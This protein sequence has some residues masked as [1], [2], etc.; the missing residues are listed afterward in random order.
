MD[1]KLRFYLDRTDNVKLK[2]I[3][4]HEDPPNLVH[5]GQRKLFLS[6]LRFLTDYAMNDKGR[7]LVIYIGA[8]PGQHL[9]LIRDL[10]PDVTFFLFDG[11]K[12]RISGKTE[13]ADFYR[14]DDYLID[15]K[16]GLFLFNELFYDYHARVLE[17]S[18]RKYLTDKDRILF[19]SDIRTTDPDK[20]YVQD[21]NVVMDLALQYHI[22]R[23]MSVDMCLLKFRFPFYEDSGD[24]FYEDSGD[25]LDKVKN[26]IMLTESPEINFAENYRNRRM[27]YFDGE[28]WPQAFQGLK[29]AETR[30][31]TS[32][33]KLKDYG[34]F[35]NYEEILF[36]YNILVR[37]NEHINEFSDLSIGFDHCGDCSIEAWTWKHYFTKVHEISS[38]RRF[39]KNHRR[40]LKNDRK[41]I[42]PSFLRHQ[43][44]KHVKLLSRV[45]KSLIQENHGRLD[46]DPYKDIF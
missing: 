2:Y 35:R 39:L 3:P 17:T 46:Y 45:T 10:F 37:P 36:G 41:S 16:P 9:S 20:D 38:S 11:A 42:N 14:L 23:I 5:I 31:V 1:P 33:R 28:I 34:E 22:V 30:L 26:S 25:I 15:M 40:F 18:F 13:K 12:F 32:G 24:P 27:V 7:T 21:H 8:A 29:S 43:V 6:E 4:D 19:I 44:I